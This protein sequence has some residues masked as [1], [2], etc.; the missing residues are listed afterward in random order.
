MR[1]NGCSA[2]RTTAPDDH[3]PGIK[4]TYPLWSRPLLTCSESILLCVARQWRRHAPV[5]IE[6]PERV[7][8]AIDLEDGCVIHGAARVEVKKPRRIGRRGLLW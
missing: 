3:N 5:T 8:R 6:L 1:H 2:R 4:L 7:L